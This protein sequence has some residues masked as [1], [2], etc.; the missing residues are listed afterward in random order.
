M[1]DT[2]TRRR[3]T[4]T[5]AATQARRV[6]KWRRWAQEMR[7]HGWTVSEPDLHPAD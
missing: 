7:E 3:N 4:D 5:T 2:A 1:E 6:K